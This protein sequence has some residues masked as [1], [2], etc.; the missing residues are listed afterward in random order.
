M[1]DTP[2][3]GACFVT[4]AEL[5]AMPTVDVA[6]LLRNSRDWYV[7]TIPGHAPMRFEAPTAATAGHY[8]LTA[9]Y[10]KGNEPHAYMSMF[11]DENP[12]GSWAYYINN[13]ELVGSI[14]QES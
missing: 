4:Q 13:R 12:D 10:G 11:G 9:I 1:N 5:D 2:E 3:A 6:E 14:L 7:V 8:A